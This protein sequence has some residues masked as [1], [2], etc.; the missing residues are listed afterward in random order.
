MKLDI[1]KRKGGRRNNFK[2][3]FKVLIIVDS[4]FLKSLFMLSVVFKLL[5]DD[6]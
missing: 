5:S 1:Y 6:F 2:M 4:Y 3:V